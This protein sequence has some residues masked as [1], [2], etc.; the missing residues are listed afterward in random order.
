MSAVSACESSWSP[1]KGRPHLVFVPHATEPQFILW[2]ENDTRC[3]LHRLG[4]STKRWLIDE[5]LQRREVAGFALPLLDAV[6]H[7]ALMRAHPL[8]RGARRPSSRWTWSR[9]K[10]SCLEQRFAR[11]ASRRV[12]QWHLAC[13]RTQ[14]VSCSL[15]NQCRSP[16]MQ[17][18]SR[19]KPL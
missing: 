8:P 9:V 18:R 7:L 3:S 16:R 13:Q 15:R 5:K 17:Y 12:S 6:S 10:D 2:G 4:A 1:A 14:S 11:I 19:H